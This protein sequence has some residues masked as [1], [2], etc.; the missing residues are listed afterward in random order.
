[1]NRLS[2]SEW[3]YVPLLPLESVLKDKNHPAVEALDSCSYD[4]KT[5]HAPHPDALAM[6][7]ARQCNHIISVPTSRWK[8]SPGQ[9][10]TNVLVSNPNL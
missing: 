5:N 3:S 9:L 2:F 10:E 4:V 6:V 8:R 1:M 7:S